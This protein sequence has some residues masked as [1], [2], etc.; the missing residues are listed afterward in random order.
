MN[1][2]A[3]ITDKTLAIIA[4]GDSFGDRASTL[5][6]IIHGPSIGCQIKR[7]NGDVCFD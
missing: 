7:H 4:L 6:A 5:V 1:M 2:L 3:V